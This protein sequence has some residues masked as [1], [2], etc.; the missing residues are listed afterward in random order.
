MY[1]FTIRRFPS[2]PIA[3]LSQVPGLQ[4]DLKY[5]TVKTTSWEPNQNPDRDGCLFVRLPK[6]AEAA[7]TYMVTQSPDF[8]G[9]LEKCEEDYQNGKPVDPSAMAVL[10][11]NVDREADPDD[12]I[13]ICGGDALIERL[14]HAEATLSAEEYGAEVNQALGDFFYNVG[15]YVDQD[16]LREALLGRMMENLR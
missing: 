11:E 9:L 12:V 7:S 14:R 3:S 8:Q 4:I 16:D 5:Q 10:F 15:I 13:D 1:K 6:G 2:G